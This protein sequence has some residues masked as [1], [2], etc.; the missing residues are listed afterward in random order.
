MINFCKLLQFKTA[1]FKNVVIVP[2]HIYCTVEVN[3]TDINQDLAGNIWW[4]SR[5]S[6]TEFNYINQHQCRPESLSIITILSVLKDFW[7]THVS[8]FRKRSALKPARS[9]CSLSA[10]LLQYLLFHLLFN[11]F[12]FS[13][14]LP[15]LCLILFTLLA[16]LQTNSPPLWHHT[17]AHLSQLISISDDLS[18][19]IGFR[20]GFWIPCGL[21]VSGEFLLNA[22]MSFS[23]CVVKTC[24][25]TGCIRISHRSQCVLARRFTRRKAIDTENNNNGK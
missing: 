24:K 22:N 3:A 6:S 5:F 11:S 12:L 2:R 19:S 7:R 21:S 20:K 16:Y 15:T 1:E 23:K 25:T 13:L 14:I 4:K 8:S 18:L 10:T 9:H 17:L